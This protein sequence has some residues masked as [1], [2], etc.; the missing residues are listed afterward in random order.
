MMNIAG[1][2]E[3]LDILSFVQRQWK[4]IGVDMKI[5]LV[6]VGTLFGQALPKRTFDMAYSFIGR[7]V[8]PDISNLFLSPDYKPTGNYSG[9]SNPELDK[10]LLDSTNTADRA[11]RKEALFKA[12]DIIADDE[13][14]L[15]LAWLTNH[16]AI[17]K[18]VQGYRPSPAYIEFWNADEWWLSS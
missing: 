17:N 14:E 4:D 8:D 18:R 11:R 7:Y 13:V 5:K 9:Y 2:K 6:D 10:V 16:T 1:E 12:Q 15:F 3:R